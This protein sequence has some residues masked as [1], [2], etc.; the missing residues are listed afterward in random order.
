MRHWSDL[1]RLPRY[2]NLDSVKMIEGR[3]FKEEINGDQNLC[4]N[5]SFKR[6]FNMD[7]INCS[8][9]LH[10]PISFTIC[11]YLTTKC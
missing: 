5:I 10:D 1:E 4:E 6:C 7:F 11:I 8:T 3:L 9:N 2:L